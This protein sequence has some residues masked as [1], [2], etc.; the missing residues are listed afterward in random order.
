MIKIVSF[1]IALVNIFLIWHVIKIL[2]CLQLINS[3]ESMHVKNPCSDLY[4]QADFTWQNIYYEKKEIHHPLFAIQKYKQYLNEILF[5]LD[6]S[7]HEL[8][9]YQMEEVKH[10]LC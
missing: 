1:Q 9:S 6:N 4:I 7:L 2:Y 10:Y 8:W 5:H 3:V